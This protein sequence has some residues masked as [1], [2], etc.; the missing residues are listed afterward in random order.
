MPRFFS[1][2]SLCLLLSGLCA[3]Q[4]R[5]GPRDSDP[6]LEQFTF[7][8]EKLTAPSMGG[9][10]LE[11]GVYL[12]KGYGD[13]KQAKRRYPLAIWLHGLRGSLWRFHHEGA[14]VLDELRKQ[15]KLPDMILVTPSAGG[16]AVYMNGPRNKEE[17]LIL[18]DLWKHLLKTYRVAEARHQ[19]AILGVSMG[20]LGAM[21]MA[22][23]NPLRFG[24][25]A[26][27]SSPV[28]PADPEDLGRFRR[29]AESIFGN[30]IDR[31]QWAREIPLA[32]LQGHDAKLLHGLRIYFDAG[33]AD[34]Y[35]FGPANVAFSKQLEKQGIQHTFRLIQGGGH[36]WGSGAIQKAMRWSLEFVGK[37][38][39]APLPKGDPS[40]AGRVAPEGAKQGAAGKS[41]GQSAE[42]SKGK[43]AQQAAGKT[44]VKTGGSSASDE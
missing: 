24:A 19:R 12:P 21:K 16:R 20:A 15:G 36:S 40:K 2:L 35:G 3:A 26:V 32:L 37:S 6:K 34:R 23:K 33:S 14:A 11:F 28:L 25:V 4:R 29:Y 5:S 7:R 41:T 43:S 17:D 10:Q 27:H 38:F 8:V 31:K 1:T 39:A 42:E 44:G 13:S 18:V 30:P 9:R 22:L